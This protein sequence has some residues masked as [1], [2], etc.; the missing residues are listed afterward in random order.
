MFAVHDVLVSVYAACAARI[1][2]V[3][4]VVVIIYKD[5]EL[6]KAVYSAGQKIAEECMN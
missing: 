5:N 3:W 6:C 2:C 1:F 4:G